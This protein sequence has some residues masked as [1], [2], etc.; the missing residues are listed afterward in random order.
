MENYTTVLTKV[1]LPSLTSRVTLSN[2]NANCHCSLGIHL[3]NKI[4]GLTYKG[5]STVWS[6]CSGKHILRN[7]RRKRL[8]K[9]VWDQSVQKCGLQPEG[10]EGPFPVRIFKNNSIETQFTYNKLYPFK[11]YDLLS[12]NKCIFQWNYHH[13]QGT[14]HF[15]NTQMIPCASLQS[16]PSFTPGSRQL[17]ICF[18]SLCISLHFLKR[19]IYSMIQYISFCF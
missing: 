3:S 11:G 15:D 16:N 6:N 1:I 9:E 7:G 2:N 18:M 12:F 4:R 8:E 13:N 10:N 14:N 19:Y 17:L 5:W